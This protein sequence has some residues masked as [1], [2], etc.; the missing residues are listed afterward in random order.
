MSTAIPTQMIPSP[1][2]IGVESLK[3]LM[4]ERIHLKPVNQA[5]EY[6]PQGISKISFRVPAYS[7]SFLDTSKT[8]LTYKLGYKSSTAQTPGTTCNPVNTGNF[9]TRIVVKT[10]AGLVVD[11]ISDY[12]VLNQMNQNMLPT[13]KSV[14]AIEGR[15]D[16]SMK[17]GVHTPT[18]SVAKLFKDTG[19]EYRHTIQAGLFSKHT[20]KWLPIGMMD[21]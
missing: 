16:A 15:L 9:I 21:A 5:V 7:N 2:S 13:C 1:L 8:F 3:S 17:D 11:D 6:T 12:H 19:I 20:D 4:P 18:Y 14:N 10:S